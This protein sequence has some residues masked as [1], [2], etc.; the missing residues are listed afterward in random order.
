MTP[1]LRPLALGLALLAGLQAAPMAQAS[2]AGADYVAMGS[3]FAAGP[4]LPPYAAGAPARC[5]R[6]ARNYAQQL[7]QRR[8]LTLVDVS[9]SG[10][11]SQ[12]ILEPWRESPAQIDAVH[13]ATRLVTLT[14]GGNDVGYIGN[15]LSASCRA[16]AAQG[17]VAS[18]RCLALRELTEEDFTALARSLRK[19]AQAIRARAPQA[20]LV[21]IDYLTVLPP[22]GTCAL[23]PLTAA[24]AEQ[25]RTVSARL[26]VITADV[27]RDAGALLLPASRLSEDHGACAAAPWVWG[28][29]APPGGAPY[30]P[31]PLGMDALA[32]ALDDALP[33]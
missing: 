22:A 17:L 12:A 27:A 7:A 15:L 23:T 11:T 4:G 13:A 10:A 16:L 21:L 9:C 20:R 5:G 6:S 28:Y 25:A 31:T 33:P 29:P 14:I 1:A 24:E 3:S 2:E 8:A 26:R 18:S 30:H 32:Q 19:V